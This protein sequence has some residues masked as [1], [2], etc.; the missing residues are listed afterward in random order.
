M[1]LQEERWR[2]RT[3]LADGGDDRP[4]GAARRV[5]GDDRPAH[6]AARHV[7]GLALPSELPRPGRPRLRRLHRDHGA[8]QPVALGTELLPLGEHAGPRQDDP[9]GDGLLDGLD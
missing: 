1:L 6:R 8:L 4:D 9:I 5:D 7:G 2:G 3:Q